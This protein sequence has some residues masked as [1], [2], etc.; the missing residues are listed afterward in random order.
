MRAPSA[1]TDL[2]KGTPPLSGNQRSF[3]LLHSVQNL[4]PPLV[5]R[6]LKK[7]RPVFQNPYFRRIPCD[8]DFHLNFFFPCAGSARCTDSCRVGI[9][10]IDLIAVLIRRIPRTW[11]W[12]RLRIRS[13][14]LGQ[15]TVSIPPRFLRPS[16]RVLVFLSFLSVRLQFVRSL[17]DPLPARYFLR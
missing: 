12:R 13:V 14:R 11:I 9:W 17:F 16:L 8:R 5:F 3:Y 2:H 15:W 7:G 10:R 6:I 4:S 1:R